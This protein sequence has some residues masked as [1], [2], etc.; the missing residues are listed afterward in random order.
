MASQSH[1]NNRY[2]VRVEDTLADDAGHVNSFDFDNEAEAKKFFD[3]QVKEAVDAYVDG[4]NRICSIE[5]T[6]NHFR[7]SWLGYDWDEDGDLDKNAYFYTCID[8]VQI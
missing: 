4:N 2:Q 5:Q 8:L 1:Q 6:E 7:V 3:A